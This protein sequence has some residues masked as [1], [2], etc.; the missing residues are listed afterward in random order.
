VPENLLDARPQAALATS[1]LARP[2]WFYLAVL[3]WLLLTVEWF[4]YQ[5]RWIS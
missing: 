3:V 4:L 2:T 5:R 1:W